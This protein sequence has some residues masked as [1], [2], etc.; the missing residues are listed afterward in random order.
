MSTQK[1]VEEL[2][3]MIQEGKLLEAFE[4]FYHDEVV[5]RE[6]NKDVREG[7]EAN[8]EYEK[9]FVNSV[10]EWHKVDVKS[11]VAE[12]DRSVV[13]WSMDFTFENGQRAQRDQVAIQEWKDGKIVE[14]RF[15]YDA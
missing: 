12:D 11:V 4:K 6:N 5:M 14:E 3:A 13:E 15:Y 10:K 7:K 1:N 9:Q 8:R 2:N